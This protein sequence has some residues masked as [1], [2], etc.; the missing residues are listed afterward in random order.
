MT[1]LPGALVRDCNE[2]TTVFQVCMKLRNAGDMPAKDF[3]EA[4][5]E[6]RTFINRLVAFLSTEI[7]IELEQAYDLS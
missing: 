7:R 2:H 6:Y 5:V 3:Y 1:A 4:A